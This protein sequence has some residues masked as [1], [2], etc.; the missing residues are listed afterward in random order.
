[1]T[2]APDNPIEPDVDVRLTVPV[3]ALVL[4]FAELIEAL[5]VRLTVFVVPDPTVPDRPS[6]PAVAVSVIVVPEIVVP[7][8]A[9]R[10]PAAVKLNTLPAPELPVTVVVPATESV[11]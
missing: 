6:E 4:T 9:L 5:E 10:L 11:M 2:G 1:M 7:T 3:A 8:P